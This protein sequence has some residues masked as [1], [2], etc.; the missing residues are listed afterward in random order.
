MPRGVGDRP[1]AVVLFADIQNYFK[2]SQIYKCIKIIDNNF[3]EAI[4]KD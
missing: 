4:V 1:E 3:V 2:S